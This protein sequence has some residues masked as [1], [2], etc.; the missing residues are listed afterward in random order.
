MSSSTPPARASEVHHLG[1]LARF[2]AEA[3]AEQLGD[4]GSSSTTMILALTPPFPPARLLKNWIGTVRPSR[5]PLRG[6][7]GMRTFL[8]VIKNTPHPEERLK[9]ASRRTRDVDAALVW[10]SHAAASAGDAPCMHGRRI[11]NSVNSPTR[12]W[13][14]IVPPCCCVTMCQLIER[15]RPFPSPVS[16]VVKNG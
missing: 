4:I 2:A 16:L 11:V 3:L 14:T 13:T 5:Q 15:P 12:L 6:F 7:L 9:G 8:N 10:S 1:A